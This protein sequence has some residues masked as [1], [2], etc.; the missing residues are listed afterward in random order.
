V[1]PIDSDHVPD[2]YSIRGQEIGK[3]IDNKTLNRQLQTPRV[4]VLFRGVQ[5]QEFLGRIGYV[6]EK[7]SLGSFRY[8][9]LE[10]IEFVLENTSQVILG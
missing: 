8:S 4:N 3:G 5:E 10:F 9:Q 6:K 2:L 7:F 1:I